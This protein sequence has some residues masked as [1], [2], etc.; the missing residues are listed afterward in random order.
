M[1]SWI[2]TG[3][4]TDSSE[5]LIQILHSSLYCTRLLRQRWD[6][7]WDCYRTCGGSACFCHV[8]DLSTT[9]AVC[10]QEAVGTTDRFSISCQYKAVSLLQQLHQSEYPSGRIH[11]QLLS[12]IC[13]E[14]SQLQKSNL[15]MYL[16]VKEPVHCYTVYQQ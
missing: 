14:R 3:D 10:I 2:W 6:G 15:E 13:A 5:I 16:W 11:T 4:S 7:V 1:C 8:Y 9:R 12:F